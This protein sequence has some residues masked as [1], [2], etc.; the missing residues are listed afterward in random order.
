MQVPDKKCSKYLCTVN[1]SI[2]VILG[3]GVS[4][5]LKTSV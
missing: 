2:V 1:E 5:M 3:K 4:S